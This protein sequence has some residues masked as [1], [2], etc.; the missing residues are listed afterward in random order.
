MN[1]PEKH[2]IKVYNGT[3]DD[4]F[5]SIQTLCHTLEYRLFNQLF[6]R[7]NLDEITNASDIN[8]GDTIP[9]MDDEGVF[10]FIGYDIGSSIDSLQYLSYLYGKIT[11]ARGGTGQ[12]HEHLTVQVDYINLDEN[13]NRDAYEW[14]LAHVDELS[15]WKELMVEQGKW[16]DV[17]F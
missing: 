4:V 7:R 9:F 14:I 2:E 11:G 12:P 1:V 10:S 3:Q 8:V 5:N 16:T 17:G 13:T 15:E 6:V